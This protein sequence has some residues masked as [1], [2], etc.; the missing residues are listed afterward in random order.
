MCMILSFWEENVKTIKWRRSIENKCNIV[1]L[2]ALVVSYFSI[3]LAMISRDHVR[4]S[5]HNE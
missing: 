1:R 2:F 4:A 5:W 3:P